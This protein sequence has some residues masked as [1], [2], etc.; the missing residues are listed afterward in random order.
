M[1]ITVTFETEVPDATSYDDIQSWLEYEL[2]GNGF[3]KSENRLFNTQ[4]EADSFSVNFE[5]QKQ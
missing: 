3:L 2:N 4:L 5:E 1:K